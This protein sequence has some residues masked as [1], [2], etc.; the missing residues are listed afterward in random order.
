VKLATKRNNKR[1]IQR[2]EKSKRFKEIIV[3]LF[4]ESKY[5]KECGNEYE[6]EYES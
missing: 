3:N 1:K 4:Q 5:E 2:S 6:S